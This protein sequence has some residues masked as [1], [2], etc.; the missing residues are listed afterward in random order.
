MRT[1]LAFWQ[2]SMLSVSAYAQTGSTRDWTGYYMLARGQRRGRSKY[3]PVQTFQDRRRPFAAL[4]EA[5][6]AGNERC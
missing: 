3:H 6:N 2:S 4:G 5:E 1:D